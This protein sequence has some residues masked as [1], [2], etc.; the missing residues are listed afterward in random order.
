M[1]FVYCWTVHRMLQMSAAQL[2]EAGI[3][4]RGIAIVNYVLTEKKSRI[5]NL[6]KISVTFG[7][8]LKKEEVRYEGG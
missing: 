2:K 1:N 7:I 3:D 6:Q 4:E 8:F 5:P